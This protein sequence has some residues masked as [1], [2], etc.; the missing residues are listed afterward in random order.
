MSAPIRVALVDDQA[1]FRTGIRMLVDSQPDLA[2]AG[3]AGN[4]REGV[5]LAAEARPDV[6]LL[7]IRM[8]VMDGYETTRKIRGLNRSDAG[9]TPIIGLS[10]NAF[11]EDIKK[12][13]AVGMNA[14]LAKP[15]NPPDLYA[16]LR[17]HVQ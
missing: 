2:F 11:A 16:A 1:L 12:A 4:G 14:Y 8:P 3:E 17:K 15:V 9:T 10:A 13:E 7:D 5:E 6:V